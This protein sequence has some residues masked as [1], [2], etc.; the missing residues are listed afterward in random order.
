MDLEHRIANYIP[1]KSRTLSLDYLN[2]HRYMARVDPEYLDLVVGILKHTRIISLEMILNSLTQQL[3]ELRLQPFDFEVLVNDQEEHAIYLHHH[4]HRFMQFM[5]HFK[6]YISPRGVAITSHIIIF[7][8]LEI[9]GLETSWLLS[10]F[11]DHQ[12]TKP[13]VHCIFGYTGHLTYLMQHVKTYQ[14]TLF[15]YGSRFVTLL[16]LSQG[17]L[18]DNFEDRSGFFKG[19]LA[20]IVLEYRVLGDYD[21]F[22]HV[23]SQGFLFT[24]DYQLDLDSSHFYGSILTHEPYFSTETGD[25]STDSEVG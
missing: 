13:D 19:K 23:Y 2:L 8:D 17:D 1:P 15:R 14:L 20:P 24:Q 4:L 10:S 21:S 12:V 22:S 6:G 9:S 16:D 3:D 18:P 25:G 5:P 7:R 11:M